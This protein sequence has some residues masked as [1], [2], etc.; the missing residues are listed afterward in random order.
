MD[1]APSQAVGPEDAD[2]FSPVA[3]QAPQDLWPALTILL[4]P[5]LLSPFGLEVAERLTLT[6]L[7]RMIPDR[8]LGVGAKWKLLVQMYFPSTIGLRTTLFQA[9]LEAFEPGDSAMIAYGASEAVPSKSPP[10][11]LVRDGMYTL[12]GTWDLNLKTGQVVR[13]HSVL[14]GNAHI[15]KSINQSSKRFEQQVRRE[16]KIELLPVDMPEQPEP[17]PDPPDVD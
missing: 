15:E 6:G 2:N 10:P 14:E 12:T 1:F 16:L 3:T 4:G 5:D 8:P 7:E 17:Q 13:E 9:R 11:Q